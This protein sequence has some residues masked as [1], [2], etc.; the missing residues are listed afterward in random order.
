MQF[1]PPHDPADTE[2]KKRANRR[3]YDRWAAA[4]AV[5]CRQQREPLS[6]RRRGPWRGRLIEMMLDRAWLLLDSGEAEACD[7]LLEFVPE[8]RAEALL[9]EYFKEDGDG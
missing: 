5:R 1:W 3:A 6:S 8:D 7:A 4:E 2:A 9:R